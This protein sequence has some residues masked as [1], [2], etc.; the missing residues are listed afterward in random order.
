MSAKVIIK[1]GFPNNFES[2]G[3]LII[4]LHKKGYT[5][6]N[7]KVHSFEAWHTHRLK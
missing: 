1:R 4:Q 5:H 3:P 7:G 6:K 2:F